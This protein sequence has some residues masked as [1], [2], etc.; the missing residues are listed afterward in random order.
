MNKKKYY[1]AVFATSLLGFILSLILLPSHTDIALMFFYDKQFERSY[2]YYRELYKQGDHSI[3]VVLP[4]VNLLLE[5]AQIDMALDLM[6][7]YAEQNSNSIDS[8]KYLAKVYNKANRNYEYVRTLEEIYLIEP[9]VEVLREKEK[10]YGYIGD[11]E[12]E[13]EALEM[14]INRYRPKKGEYL[15]LAYQYAAK[16]DK[17]RAMETVQLFLQSVPLKSLDSPAVGFAINLLSMQDQSEQALKI[18]R[19]Y[20][21]LYPKVEVAT[22]LISALQEGSLY[23]EALVLVNELPKEDQEREEILITRV[24]LN[25]SKNQPEQAFRLLKDYLQKGKMPPP[26]YVDLLTLA[27]QFQEIDILE[28]TILQ[29][30][31]D[32]IP[33]TLLVK[34]LYTAALVGDDPSTISFMEVLPEDFVNEHST[35]SLALTIVDP[36]I[37]VDEKNLLF[38]EYSL[39]FTSDYHK[40]IL[41]QMLQTLVSSSASASVLGQLESFDGIPYDE[42]SGLLQ[43]YM[44]NGLFAK[45]WDLIQQAKQQEPNNKEYQRFWL[46]MAAANNRQDMIEESL[47]EDGLVDPDLLKD[48]FYAAFDQKHASLS[49]VL[50][51]HLYRFRPTDN[52]KKILAEA[53]ML[54]GYTEWANEI[55]RELLGKGYDVA[56]LY[57]NTLVVLAS[58]KPEYS[59]HL[60]LAVQGFIKYNILSEPTWRNL[61]W[62][63]VEH[64]KKALAAT[65]FTQLA[66]GKAVDHPDMNALLW[67]L[68]KEV[69]DDQRQWILSH[70]MASK[71]ENK[72][73]WLQYFLDSE[74]PELTMQVVQKDEWDEELIAD[75]YIEALVMTKQ[76]E[77]LKEV[78]AYVIPQESRLP[79]LKKL[80]TLAYGQGLRSIAESVF[81]KV[82]NEDPSDKDAIFTLGEI[83]Y[84]QGD[85]SYALPFLQ[86]L[87][88]NFLANYYIAEMLQIKGFV[89]YA[90]RYYECAYRLF[91]QTE[92]PTDAQLAVQAVVLFRLGYYSHAVGILKTLVSKYPENQYWRADL[93]NILIELSCLSEARCVLWAP[94]EDVPSETL[95][96]AR[97]RYYSASLCYYQA[98]CLSNEL[99]Q[100]YPKSARVRA[101][102]SSLEWNLRRWRKA[103]CYNRQA[104]ALD[105]DNEIYCLAQNEIMRTHRRE[106]MVG[107]EYRITGEYQKEYYAYFSYRHPINAANQLFF[108][109]D[110]DHI[111]AERYINI[112]TGVLEKRGG[113]RCKGALSWV[114]R[115]WCGDVLTPTVYFSEQDVGGGIHYL[116]TDLIGSTLWALEYNRPNWDF[117]QTIIDYGTRDMVAVKR[118]Q[119]ICPRFEV[120][121]GAG[122]NR[123]SLEGLTEAA[124]SWSLEGSATYLLSKGN[125]LR[126]LMGRDGIISFNYYLDAEYRMRVKERIG[127]FDQPFTPLPLISRETHAAFVFMAKRF[128]KCLAI[129]GFGGMSYDREAGGSAVPI[130]GSQIF[131]GDPDRFHGRFEYSHSTSTEFSNEDV[132]RFLLDFRWLW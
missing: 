14:I 72:V 78:I 67:I 57:V 113:E 92:S 55:A 100:E 108:Q 95:R 27:V 107:G 39:E 106:V 51:N 12:S 9:T 111:D 46:V 131:F 8:L 126:E 130:W 129:D 54:N 123:Y 59:D 88:K 127:P 50:A 5:Y 17:R 6:E 1:F 132:D 20:Y 4:L 37:S 118:V 97:M 104:R 41:S 2:E 110:F 94:M 128:G 99:L 69:S 62:L 36:S 48:I 105:P 102:R 98:L 120:S 21:S 80:G 38:S 24:H 96:L 26:L 45:G 58:E 49:M 44:S 52:N 19:E 79:R 90:H 35:L 10:Y 30:R 31:L 28:Q 63:M 115:L 64:Q 16:G 7:E 93:A 56:E 86:K 85:Y 13:L 76:N 70:A 60:D 23:D 89:G 112:D 34:V 61:G 87:P 77:A 22:S 83:Y 53:L 109:L 74:Q 15:E 124:T 66:N 81:V 75:K 91:C 40:V 71:G 116:Q 114:H 11:H 84:S 119:P 103:F 18:A 101:E 3:K 29:S 32:K 122:L 33:E 43:L 42:L 25:L 73:K 117:T 68:G 47:K 121:L 125:F 65:I 82:L